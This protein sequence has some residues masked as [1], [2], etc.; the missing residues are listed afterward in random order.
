MDNNGHKYIF[1]RYYEDTKG[2]KL[3]DPVTRK[4][5]IRRDVQF[6]ENEAWDGTVE[7]IVKIFT[8]DDISEEENA[9]HVAV[10]LTVQT[11]TKVSTPRT[12]TFVATQIT[13]RRFA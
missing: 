4:V 13:P 8:Y 1:V 12:A 10:P 5:I 9:D 2:Y 11:P 3:Y 7:K 6:V